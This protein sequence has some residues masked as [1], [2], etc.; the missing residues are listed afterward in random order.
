MG[1]GLFFL[2]NLHLADVSGDTDF[3]FDNSYVWGFFGFQI[4]RVPGPDLGQAR[5]GPGLGPLWALG[6]PRPPTV[7]LLHTRS[8]THTRHSVEVQICYLQDAQLHIDVKIMR[9][10]NHEMICN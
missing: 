10:T 4:S 3:D 6:T 5:F 2:T 7:Y 1:P 8:P 9:I